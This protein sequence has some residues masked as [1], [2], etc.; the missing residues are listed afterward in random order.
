MTKFTPFAGDAASVSIAKLKIERHRP[1]RAVRQ[2]GPD[3]DRQG[4]R[5]A[6]L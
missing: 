5:Q 1:D 4:L 3:Q 2:L 6:A